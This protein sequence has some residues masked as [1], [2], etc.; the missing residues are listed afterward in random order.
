MTSERTTEERI[1][2]FVLKHYPAARKVGLNR[3]DKW[4]ETGL[5]D[6]LGILDLVQFLEGEF[7]LSVADDELVPENFQSLKAV[8]D[9]VD[10]RIKSA[11]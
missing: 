11:R 6:S 9:F 10:A 5:V 8:T 4:L 7:S 2:D 1:R 3:E